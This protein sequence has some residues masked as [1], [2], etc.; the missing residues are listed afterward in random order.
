MAGRFEVYKD[1]AGY[2]SKAN[3]LNGIE[4]VRANAGDLDQYEKS[5]TDTGKLRF[6]LKAK[7]H[8]VIG[9]SQNYQS[10][11]GRNNG[12]EAVGRAVDGAEVEDQT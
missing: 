2:A 5:T 11:S 3:A 7:N 4:S 9:Q 6:A 8:E 12:I 1:T 10:A